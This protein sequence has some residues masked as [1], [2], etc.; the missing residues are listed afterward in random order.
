M[1]SQVRDEPGACELPLQ[2]QRPGSAKDRKKC[3]IKIY[4]PY[5][6]DVMLL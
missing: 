6:H 1:G 5:I 4:D 2:G 3:G